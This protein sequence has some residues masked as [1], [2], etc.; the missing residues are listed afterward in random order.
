MGTGD[1][2]LIAA[3][4]S[5]VVAE[6]LPDPIIVEN[7]QGD[8][9]FPDSASADESDRTKVF[10]EMHDLLNQLVT[11]KEGPRWR[12]WGFPVW[13]GSACE[14]SGPSGVKLLTWLESVEQSVVIR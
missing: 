11:P 7:G 1:W 6:S 10:G 3:D 9:G 2:E 5:A 12:R 14:I 4:E 13:A 8:R